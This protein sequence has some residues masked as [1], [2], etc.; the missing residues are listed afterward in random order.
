M[1]TKEL[2]N[3]LFPTK[4]LTSPKNLKKFNLV[5]RRDELINAL[6]K[7][8]PKYEINS[9]AR[10]CAFLGNCGIETDYFK[11]TIE[12]ASGW[13]YDISINPRK[14][15]ELGNTTKGD[16]P[17]YKGSGLT[18]TTGKFNFKA[19]QKAIGKILGIDVV[20]NPELLRQ[21]IEV[22][23]ESACIFWRDNNLNY[24]ADKG[25]FK[26]L[27]AIVNRGDKNLTPLHWEKR[28]A[29]YKVC[30]G[31]V[32]RNFKFDVPA[33]TSAEVENQAVAVVLTPTETSPE[34]LAVPPVVETNEETQTPEV[35]GATGEAAIE[36]S[37]VKEFGEKYLKHCKNDSVK[38]IFA[39]L[40]TRILSSITSVWAMGL[41]GK[42]LLIVA[43]LLIAGFSAYA[44]YYY[45]PR[46]TGWAKDIFDSLLGE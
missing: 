39:V 17:K 3:S 29:L 13:D 7:F 41:S 35:S 24:Y 8:L 43:A 14:A 9:Y 25:R 18:Q 32:P 10:L 31:T 23:V 42:I 11:T 33:E 30:L 26:E 40:G 38:N 27:S 36:K 22:A 4:G 45:A 46:I 15:R 44:L 1:I 5:R 19:V 28:N 21:N 16:G 34:S 6:N 37:K 12:Y 20:A 2:F